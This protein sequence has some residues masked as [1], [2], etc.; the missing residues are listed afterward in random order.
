VAFILL[1]FIGGKMI[2]ES[3][4]DKNKEEKTKENYFHFF[5]MLV[6]AIATSIDALAMGIT[7]AFFE[8]NILKAVIIIGLTTFSISMAGV[9][10]G[11]IFGAKYQS[12]A[13]FLGGAILILLGVKIL[14][15]HL[16][17]NGG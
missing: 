13:E 3:F 17:F 8:I 16:F 1:C 15:E 5:S 12:K 9:K 2:K 11:N 10:I 6:L 4:S 14:I 7:F